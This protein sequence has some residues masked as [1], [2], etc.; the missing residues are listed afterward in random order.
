MVIFAI[1]ESYLNSIEIV[2]FLRNKYDAVDKLEPLGPLN[3]PLVCEDVPYRYP[4][5]PPKGSVW[6]RTA[7]YS[8]R[9]VPYG[10]ICSYGL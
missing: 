1:R 2:S 4:V 7:P 8:P 10:S 5:G 9:I 6:P 3:S